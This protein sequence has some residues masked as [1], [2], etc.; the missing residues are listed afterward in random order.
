[1]LLYKLGGS[2]PRELLEN[3]Y[4]ADWS[5]DGNEMAIID[6]VNNRWRLQYPMGKVLLE[7]ENWMSDVRVSPDGKQVAL[8]RSAEFCAGIVYRI[9]LLSPADAV[10]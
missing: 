9:A 4:D 7:G 1:M 5:P 10:R 8:F 2:A 3:V 6:G